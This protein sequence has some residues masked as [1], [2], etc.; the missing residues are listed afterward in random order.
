MYSHKTSLAPLIN[1]LL[2]VS[3]LLCYF[4]FSLLFISLWNFPEIDCIISAF[5]STVKILFLCPVISTFC[6]ILRNTTLQAFPI[7]PENIPAE[8]FIQLTFCK[9]GTFQGIPKYSHA[10]GTGKCLICIYPV[11]ITSKPQ[12]LNA[13]HLHDV[14]CMLQGCRKIVR[15]FLS[16]RVCQKTGIKIQSHTAS[17]LCQP[18]NHI[19]R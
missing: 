8:N 15:L 5:S 3:S 12:H 7:Y 4:F 19:V 11:E 16:G 6:S 1:R 13:S 17:P 9:R 2:S 18:P 14:L 10:L